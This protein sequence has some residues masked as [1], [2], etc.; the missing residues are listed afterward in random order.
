MWLYPIHILAVIL[1]AST[2]TVKSIIMTP[3]AIP[4]IFLTGFLF[5]STLIASRFSVGQLEPLSYISVRLL[6]AS[7]GYLLFYLLNRRPF[8]TDRTLWKHAGIFGVFGTASNLVLIVSTLQYLSSGLT[9]IFITISPAATALLAHFLLPEER[10]EMRQWIG[11]VLALSGAIMLAIFGENGLPEVSSSIE[12]YLMISLSV[13]ISSSMTIYA[14]V[15]LQRYD[16][17]DSSS[18]RMWV[19][20][21]TVVP[22]TFFFI[23]F[24]FSNATSQVFFAILYA[25]LMGT[26]GGFFFQLYTI[27]QFGVIPSS[28]VTYVIPLISGIGGVLILGETFTTLMIIGVLII[29]IGIMLVQYRPLA[30]RS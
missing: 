30:F 22:A 24:D 17:I 10:L 28:M 23:G 1:S 26:L 3:K 7:S 5:G 25:G 14:R 11:I 9:A 18:I 13:I 4:Y 16:A 15:N 20:T 6:I 2:H 19:A 8:P 21:L 27:K 29:I 12:G